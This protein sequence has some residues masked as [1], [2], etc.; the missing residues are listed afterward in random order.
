MQQWSESGFE[1]DISINLSAVDLADPELEQSILRHTRT[2]GVRP[3][4]I[5]FEITESAVMRETRSVIVTMERL[6]KHG[7]RFSVDDFGT[8]YS[9]LAQFRNLP[10]DEIKIDKSFVMDLRPDSDD[11]AIVRS[12]IDLGHNLGV[13][14]VAEGVETAD[15]WRLLQA[16]GCDLAQGYLISKP[17]PADEVVPRLKLLNDALLAADTATQQLKVLRA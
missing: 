7:F 16:L 6:R 17:L 9:S 8:G 11:A 5:V 15:G 14:V 1:P 3:G 2:F 12:T 4:R 10:F 13:K